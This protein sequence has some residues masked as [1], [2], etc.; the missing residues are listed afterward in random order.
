MILIL[1]C[2]LH[3]ATCINSTKHFINWLHVHVHLVLMHKLFDTWKYGTIVNV[4]VT[5]FGDTVL[6]VSLFGYYNVLLSFKGHQFPKHF[7]CGAAKTETIY[8]E[9]PAS[10]R[11]S[12]TMPISSLQASK[13]TY[14]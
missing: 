11:L 12:I 4:I 13:H 14:H 3:L 7:I 6:Y 10:G 2:S 9:D 1:L 8:C 5:V